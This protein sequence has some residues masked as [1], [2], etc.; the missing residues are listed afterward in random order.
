MRAVYADAA[1]YPGSA[2]SLAGTSLTRDLVFGDDGGIHQLATVTGDTTS[3]YVANLTI[4][5]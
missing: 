3:G 4:G 1:T 5:V 2:D